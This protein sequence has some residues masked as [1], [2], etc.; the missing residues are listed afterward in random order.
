VLTRITVR[1]KATLDVQDPHAARRQR[2]FV[3]AMAR[4]LLLFAAALS[5]TLAFAALTVWDV[6]GST[7]WSPALLLTPV[8]LATIGLVV[9]ALRVGQGG[10]R[11]RFTEPEPGTQA[12][13]EDADHT[14]TGT[15][16]RDDDRLWK[17]GLFYFNR[18]DPAVWVQKRFGVG[19]TLNWARPAA[20]ATLAGIVALA[21]LLP[22]LL[23]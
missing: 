21:I 13:H 1:G 8:A 11:L 4:C 16:N 23:R 20:L 2:R 22:V 17:S 18:D 19:W 3:A 10:S 9:V 14:S 15:V 5:L 6:I 7:G 12:A